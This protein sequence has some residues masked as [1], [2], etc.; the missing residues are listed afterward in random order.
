ME[1]NMKE[2][3]AFKTG[4]TNMP[5]HLAILTSEL[6]LYV[7]IQRKCMAGNYNTVISSRCY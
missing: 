1:K 4:E 6:Y 2:Y 7:T 3:L 5:Q